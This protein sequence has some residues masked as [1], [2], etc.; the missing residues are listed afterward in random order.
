M[1]SHRSRRV[2]GPWVGCLAAVLSAIGC[3]GP[4]GGGG[5]AGDWAGAVTTEGNVTTVVNESGSVWGGTA[6]LVEEASIGVEM[7]EEAY[8]LGR[9]TGIWATD[10]EIF[11]IDAQIP[12]IRVYDM[13]GRHLRDLGA[14]GQG[15]GEFAR[16]QFITGTADGRILVLD[17]GSRRINVYESDPDEAASWPVGMSQCCIHPM[18]MGRDGTL[19]IEGG[20]VNEQDR[21]FE[22]AIQAT[23]PDGPIGDQLA[24]PDFDYERWSYAYNGRQIES[25]PNAPSI[26]WAIHPDGPL[27][28]GASDRYRFEILSPNGRRTV[29]ER[30]WDPVPVTEDEAEFWRRNLEERYARS[31]A[32]TGTGLDWDGRMPATKPAYR[33]FLASQSGEI[34][35]LREGPAETIA[36]CDP[37]DPGD[38][39]TEMISGTRV[40]LPGAC[41]TIS[42]LI[43]VF[44]GD[45]RYLGPVEGALLQPTSSFVRGEML[46][47]PTEDESGTVLVKRYRVVPPSRTG[48]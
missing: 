2:V 12:V 16:P 36:G 25:V 22:Q 20:I 8:M 37:T 41:F 39:A 26:V 24:V 11:V 7:G 4:T 10:A 38:A 48:S 13:D 45:G 30:F 47:T 19:W 9:V 35:V 40:R 42:I 14:G 29:V 27:V 1:Q 17:P 32:G 44:G 6:T 31:E 18:M 43:D 46:I 33:F 21:R 28:A 15:P 23:G 34:W 5:A 3:D